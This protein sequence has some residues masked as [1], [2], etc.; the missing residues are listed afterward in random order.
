MSDDA[1]IA[2]ARLY[3]G[4]GTPA[5][6]RAAAS[7]IPGVDE[8]YAEYAASAVRCAANE[9]R[10]SARGTWTKGLHDA[11]QL[12]YEAEA[13]W[14]EQA[15]RVIQGIQRAVDFHEEIGVVVR[16]LQERNNELFKERD[17]AREELK[18]AR[19]SVADL[20]ARLTYSWSRLTSA[21]GHVPCRHM[22]KPLAEVIK[23][24]NC[25]YV[26]ER[27]EKEKVQAELAQC[28]E[29]LPRV[30]REYP[31]IHGIRH[32]VIALG[33]DWQDEVATELLAQVT[34]ERD[35]A[36]KKLDR[37]GGPVIRE[38]LADAEERCAA[39]EATITEA[40]KAVR[41]TIPE[42]CGGSLAE[43][44]RTMRACMNV[45]VGCGVRG[46]GK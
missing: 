15:R 41:E 17:E 43:A 44:I 33:S 35:E 10:W 27:G 25:E 29:E 37:D 46:R 16:G 18:A 7:L 23:A 36:I 30:L 38:M 5:E 14:A 12:D 40:W 45:L 28:R 22:G 34:K 8:V 20:D 39:N 21:E 1:H 24:M 9:G 11:R 6:K 2:I 13:H 19:E 42:S 32:L 4:P 31:V 3:N 26:T